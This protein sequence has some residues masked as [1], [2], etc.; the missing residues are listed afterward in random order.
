MGLF[1]VSVMLFPLCVL[2]VPFVLPP[3]VLQSTTVRL[4][5]LGIIAVLQAW[6]NFLVNFVVLVIFAQA[7]SAFQIHHSLFVRRVTGVLRVPLPP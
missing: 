7:I 4:V 1:V 2:P 6:V 3:E 5:L